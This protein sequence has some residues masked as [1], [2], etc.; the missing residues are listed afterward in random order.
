MMEIDLPEIVAEVKAAFERYERAVVSNDVETLDQLFHDDSRTIRYGATENLYGYDEIKK[1]RAAR[2]PVG[3]ARTLS[4]TVITTYG[5]DYAVASTLF[6]RDTAP[7]KIGRQTQTWVRC[8][9]GWRVVV[10]HVSVIDAP[11][12][13]SP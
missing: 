12:E 2:S 13:P 11:A 1:F 4:R 9:D 3:L 7:G 10:G 6:H 8:P 5:R